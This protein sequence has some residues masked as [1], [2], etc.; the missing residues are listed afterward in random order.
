MIL[1]IE[2]DNEINSKRNQ[3]QRAKSMSIGERTYSYESD[4]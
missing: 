4:V 2:D 1:S 3:F